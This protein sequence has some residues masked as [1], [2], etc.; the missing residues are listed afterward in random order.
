MDMAWTQCP[1]CGK[2]VKHP[3]RYVIRVARDACAD[4]TRVRLIA[5][6]SIALHSCI[7][8]AHQP[9]STND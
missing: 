4:G 3:G 7:A 8:P 9:E 5:N 1:Q 6:D 2:Q